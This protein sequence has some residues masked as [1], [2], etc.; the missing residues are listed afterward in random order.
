[1][2]NYGGSTGY[3][4]RLADA[5]IGEAEQFYIALKDAGVETVLVRYPREGHGLRETALDRAVAWYRRHFGVVT[6]K[7]PGGVRSSRP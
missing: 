6:D 3:G 4:Q 7:P 2:V 5:T 1:M